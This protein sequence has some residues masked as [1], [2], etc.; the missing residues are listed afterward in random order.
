[1][2]LMAAH[3]KESLMDI[4]IG[5]NQD[6]IIILRV[7]IRLRGRKSLLTIQRDIHMRV[8]PG[9]KVGKEVLKMIDLRRLNKA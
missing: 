6:L 5:L 2:K 1:M 4:P 8:D 3:Q 9:M 7:R